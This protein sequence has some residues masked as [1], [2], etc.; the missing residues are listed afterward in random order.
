M[1][2]T[3]GYLM[4]GCSLVIL[5]LVTPLAACLDA[6]PF[7]GDQLGAKRQKVYF[8]P[9]V[10]YDEAQRLLVYL[11]HYGF[12]EPERT[13]GARGGGLAAALRKPRLGMMRLDLRIAFAAS[14]NSI[15]ERIEQ[16]RLMAG[17]A[18]HDLFDGTRIELALYDRRN[19]V[20]WKEP[21][22]PDVGELG[23][24]FTYGL[25]E[26]FVDPRMDTAQA[27]QIGE[28]LLALGFFSQRERS[29]AQLRR[30]KNGL[31]ELRLVALASKIPSEDRLTSKTGAL[32]AWLKRLVSAEALEVQSC[33]RRFRRCRRFA[34]NGPT[35]R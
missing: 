16:L 14:V 29:S 2:A 4:R 30:R 6:H 7:E 8:H 22:P 9:P 19:V 12:Y 25:G 35:Q 17:I 18:A 11:R 20:R 3:S 26:L 32:V 23:A 5:A 24:R 31:T 10:S 1:S 34:P 15:D 28:R 13:A 33:G 21:L 27:N